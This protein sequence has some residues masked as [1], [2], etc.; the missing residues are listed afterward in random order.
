MRPEWGE[1]NTTGANCVGG[2]S[3]VKGGV[4]SARI[5]AR[6][7]ACMRARR[8]GRSK[9]LACGMGYRFPRLTNCAAAAS[10]GTRCATLPSCKGAVYHSH[11]GGRKTL[12]DT[13]GRS[14][15]ALPL[16]PGVRPATRFD[17]VAIAAPHRAGPYPTSPT[18]HCPF[19]KL[20][21]DLAYSVAYRY[22]CTLGSIAGF[23][24][25]VTTGHHERQAFT[26]ASKA[27]F[28][29]GRRRFDARVSRACARQGGLRSDCLRQWSG[30]A[31]TPKA[32]TLQLAV[33]RY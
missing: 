15:A 7:L 26:L 11:A 28:A 18:L 5:E 27:H 33:D 14:L 16:T 19:T 22:C 21:P 6:S 9:A 8:F 4:S 12:D 32:G 1:Q 13:F 2:A 10:R 3:S 29:R 30:G 20:A 31:R 24:I 25:R 23:L 17:L